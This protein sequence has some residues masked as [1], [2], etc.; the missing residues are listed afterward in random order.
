MTFDLN[1]DHSNYPM[2]SILF[3]VISWAIAA[4]DIVALDQ[5]ILEPLAHLAAF[6]SGVI[7]VV[8]GCISIKE[9]LF[10]HQNK[11]P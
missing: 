3:A 8:L 1:T 2:L 9:K 7:A 4:I 10:K 6:S 5:S 11:Q